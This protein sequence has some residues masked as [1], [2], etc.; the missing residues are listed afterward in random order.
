MLCTLSFWFVACNATINN[1]EHEKDGP[2]TDKATCEAHDAKWFDSQNSAESEGVCELIA[3][4][5]GKKCTDKADCEKYCAVIEGNN[6]FGEC[7]DYYTHAYG[8]DSSWVS[9]KIESWCIDP[10]N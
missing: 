8:C 10:K 7:A 2:Y 4:D 9:G 5:K 3:T 6:E 1:E